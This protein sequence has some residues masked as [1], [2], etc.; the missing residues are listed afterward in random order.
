MKTSF[1]L[2]ASK[3][4]QDIKNCDFSCLQP[5]LNDKNPQ[6]ARTKFKIHTKML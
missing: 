1:E 2:E 3:K 6:T 4:L 5:Y